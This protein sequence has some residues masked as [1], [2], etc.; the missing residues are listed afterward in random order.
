MSTSNVTFQ[1][2]L[3]LTD[4]LAERIRKHGPITFHEWMKEALYHET[5]GYYMRPDAEIW[6]RR[7]DYRTSP[8]TSE[9]FAATFARYVSGLFKELGNPDEFHFVECG[10]GD[11]RFAEGL[12]SSLQNSF[13]DTYEAINYCIDDV[14]KHRVS[15]ISRRLQKFA[16]KIEFTTLEAVRDLDPGIVFSNELLDTFPVHRLTKR[17]GELK[18]LYV[19]VDDNDRFQWITGSLSSPRL[20]DIYSQNG[21]DV[22]EDQIIEVSPEIDDWLT[23][24]SEKLRR[25]YVVTVDYGAESHELYRSQDRRSGTLRA[26]SRHKVVEVLEQPGERDVTV[27][28]NWTR[29]R[30]VGTSLGLKTV[31]FQRQDKFLLDAG[32]LHE[33]ARLSS[34]VESESAAARLALGAREMF[35]PNGMAT[36]F[37]VLVQANRING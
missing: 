31:T 1:S 4:C 18:E 13:P 23:L 35:L 22:V 14:N 8:E 6:G 28:V 20:A 9:L 27:H 32:I 19:D 5:E 36:S 17:N 37:H 15:A 3:T 21:V 12:L 11:G 29:V 25:G 30:N 26:Y 24:V 10:A 33:L 16:S 7:W 34:A 2:S